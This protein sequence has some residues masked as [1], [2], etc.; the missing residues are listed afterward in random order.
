MQLLI[1]N[2]E[3]F[4]DLQRTTFRYKLS[5]IPSL[6]HCPT[7]HIEEWSISYRLSEKSN[8]SDQKK[9]QSDDEIYGSSELATE[10]ITLVLPLVSALF[11][12]RDHLG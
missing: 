5:K 2:L 9:E 8:S 1:C 3:N 6:L 11:F 4:I 12:V 10:I 7:R